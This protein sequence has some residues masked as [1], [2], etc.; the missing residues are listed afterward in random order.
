MR[1]LTTLV[2]MATLF[3]IA[4]LIAVPVMDG[5][6]PVAIDIAPGYSGQITGIQMA[7]VKWIVPVFIGTIV[8]WSVF[9]ILRQERQQVR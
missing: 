8:L 4:Y 1:G 7:L 6:A 5:L 2:V 3:V 9:W